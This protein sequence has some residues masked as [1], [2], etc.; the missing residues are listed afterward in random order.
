MSA[1]KPIV[2]I[3]SPYSKGD[4]ACNAH[5]QCAVFD[6]LMNEGKAWPIVP[7]WTHF[8]HLMFPRPYEHWIEY[9]RALLHLYD[10]CVRLNAEVPTIG[11]SEARSTGADK[12]VEYMNSLGKPIF[13]SIAELYE[14][15]DAGCP[16]KR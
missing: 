7:L 15:I 4:P 8:Q 6:Q 16:P 5:F 12:E 9:D 13:Y 14:W 1:H 2:Y 10:A 11:Y 3:A